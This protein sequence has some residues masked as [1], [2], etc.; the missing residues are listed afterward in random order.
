MLEENELVTT[1]QTD[2]DW[3][4]ASS[5]NVSAIPTAIYAQEKIDEAVDNILLA[6]DGGFYLI[7]KNQE[8]IRLIAINPALL[9]P[10]QGYGW[11]SL[12]ASYELGGLPCVINTINQAF[13]LDINQYIFMNSEAI[14]Q[15]SDKG[16]PDSCIIRR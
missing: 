1:S 4:S 16:R 13:G 3:Q 10:V 11:T 9:V 6:L 7:S 8:K 2:F 12:A 5:V 14:W 15:V